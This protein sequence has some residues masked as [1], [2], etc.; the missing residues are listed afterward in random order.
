MT[1]ASRNNPEKYNIPTSA[2]EKLR[3]GDVFIGVVAPFYSKKSGMINRTL[4]PVVKIK[5][6]PPVLN[7]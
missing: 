2:A 4:H 1:T 7:F 5:S 3:T 6:E